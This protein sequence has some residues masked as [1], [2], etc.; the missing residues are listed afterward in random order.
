MKRL[1]WALFV[2]A[3]AVLLI[4]A[5]LSPAAALIPLGRPSADKIGIYTEVYYYSTTD[6]LLAYSVTSNAWYPVSLLGGELIRGASFAGRII[7]VATDKR[8]LGFSS[9]FNEWV[10]VETLPTEE[11]LQVFAQNDLGIVRTSK[12]SL[13][14]SAYTNDWSELDLRYEPGGGY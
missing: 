5:G 6:L 2:G 11:I 9:L 1:S 14:F 10:L 8:I 12:R 13:G 4:V 3:A 7:V